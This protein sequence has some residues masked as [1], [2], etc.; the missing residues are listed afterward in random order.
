VKAT[1]VTTPFTRPGTPIQGKQHGLAVLTA[2][3]LLAAPLH[4]SGFRHSTWSPLFQALA[5]TTVGGPRSP[6]V[7]LTGRASAGVS[8][9]R[10]DADRMP[11]KVTFTAPMY[12][13][14]VSTWCMS[15]ICS[16]V[17]QPIH[18]HMS[19]ASCP[20]PPRPGLLW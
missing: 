19:Q 17:K 15:S 13:A 5:A 2:A 7:P 10:V 6:Q 16:R 14:L 20:A 4:M 12:A 9:E 11:D 3:Y 8:P 18:I 1:G